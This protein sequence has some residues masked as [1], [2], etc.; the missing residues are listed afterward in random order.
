MSLPTFT[1]LQKMDV[2]GLTGPFVRGAAKTSIDLQTM[3]VAG[4]T[5]PFMSNYDSSDVTVDIDPISSGRGNSTS[6]LLRLISINPVS[7]G[8]GNGLAA[9]DKI[10]LINAISSGRGDG[11]ATTYSDLTG[12]TVVRVY[13]DHADGR[14]Y[15]GEVINFYVE[16]NE[17][18][19]K[20]AGTLR[21]R[22][23]VDLIGASYVSG[24]GTDTFL[25]QYTVQSDDSTSDLDYF[26]ITS[27]GGTATVRD[28]FGN[29]ADKTLPAPGDPG[30]VSY[31]SEIALGPITMSPVSSGSGTSNSVHS[32]TATS[33]SV[34]SGYGDDIAAA[35]LRLLV[36]PVSSGR[37]DS[38]AELVIIPQIHAISSGLGND[39][40][41]LV[42]TSLSGSLS[43]GRGTSVAVLV[44]R[45]NGKRRMVGMGPIRTYSQHVGRHVRQHALRTVQDD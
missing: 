36:H 17:V 39:Y 16:F 24:S 20:G 14:F 10:G 44:R 23:N 26:N 3:D 21:L 30:S 29:D 12:P 25:L 40:A 2:A 13:T 37:G 31:S 11:S 32:K 9:H 5:G 43:S 8:R 18:T 34:S 33:D 7:S 41:A 4:L 15:D 1:D 45:I 19:F 22:L 35:L 6:V 42:R 38:A 28:V 27:L